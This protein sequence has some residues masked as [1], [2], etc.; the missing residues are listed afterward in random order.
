MKYI[1]SSIK[2]T[3]PLI[4]QSLALALSLLHCAAA[5]EQFSDSKL[6]IAAVD[7]EDMDEVSVYEHTPFHTPNLRSSAKE[8]NRIKCPFQ[9][10]E[11]NVRNRHLKK[12]KSKKKILFCS[13]KMTFI[14][15]L[16]ALQSQERTN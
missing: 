12:G 8:A 9:V 11:R 10:E 5:K 3:K 14:K 1:H 7:V 13:I 6:I 15:E 16:I 2:N 4:K